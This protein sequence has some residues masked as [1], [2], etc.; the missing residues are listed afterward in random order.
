M[1]S[2]KAKQIRVWPE[3]KKQ[4]TTC[5]VRPDQMEKLRALSQATGV[6]MAEYVRR[7]IDK[8]LEKNRDR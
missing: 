1:S 8:V 7:G 2:V 6:P 3:H 4:A 5:Y